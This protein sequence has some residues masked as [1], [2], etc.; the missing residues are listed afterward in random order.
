MPDRRT[1]LAGGLALGLTSCGP[2]IRQYRG[3]E[4]T[5]VVVQKGAR[6]MYLLHGSEVLKAY[7]IDLGF[8]PNGDKSF[9]GD[10]RTPEGSYF[11]DR[12]NPQSEFHLSLGVSYPNEQDLAEAEELGLNPGG[13][14]FIHGAS[15]RTGT[16]GTDWTFG[17]IA[18]SN[19]EIEDVYAMVRGGTQIDIHP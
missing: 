7:D 1:V 14:I 11:I 3:P 12:K 6:R 15:G 8:E 13:D 9:E 5:R 19:R 4:V 10:G 18:V 17:C 2:A 16:R